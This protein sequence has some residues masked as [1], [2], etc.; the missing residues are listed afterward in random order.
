[1]VYENLSDNHLISFAERVGCLWKYDYRGHL[2][3]K[4]HGS[5]FIQHGKGQQHD[6]TRIPEKL[7]KTTALTS[8]QV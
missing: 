7:K 6:I 1:M 2:S 4:R 5:V 8:I 3:V